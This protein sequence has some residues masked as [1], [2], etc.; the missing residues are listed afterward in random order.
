ML[1]DFADALEFINVDFEFS[2]TTNRIFVPM[3]EQHFRFTPLKGWWMQNRGII[4]R[5]AY[6]DHIPHQW[7]FDQYDIDMIE[8]TA[9]EIYYG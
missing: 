3:T 4:P 7:G 2:K 6:I 1:F 8:V 5:V 9:T